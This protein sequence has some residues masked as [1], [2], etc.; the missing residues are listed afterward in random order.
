MSTKFTAIDLY[1]GCGGL[2]QG[3]TQAGFKVLAACEI[4]PKAAYTYSLNHP[5]VRVYRDDIRSLSVDAILNDLGIEPGTLD[6]LAGCPPCQGFSRIGT[7]NGALGSDDERNELVFEFLRFIRGLQPKT[8]MIENVPALLKDQRWGKIQYQLARLGY[9]YVAKVIDA[10]NY[11]VPQRRKRMILLASRVHVPILAKEHKVKLDVRSA[12]AHL[13]LP[14][15]STDLLHAVP[16]KRSEKVRKLIRAVP[17]D[18]GSRSELPPRFWL[19]CHRRSSGFTDVYGR[20]SWSDLAPTITSGC[21]NPSKGR[22]LHPDQNRAITLREAA[23]L[24]GF[25]ATY[26][27]EVGHGKEA[28]SLMIGNALPPPFIAAHARALKK[29]LAAAAS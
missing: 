26:K 27:F 20:M 21:T 14:S 25:P 16:E 22:F 3:L 9:E 18:G 29:G 28:I 17:R 2:T 11:S 6:L 4:D 23:L 13:E 1:S 19:N 24:Q 7:R 15:G 10:A 12:I 8:I 5:A